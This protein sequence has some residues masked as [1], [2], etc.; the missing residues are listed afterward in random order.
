MKP[1][2][3][4]I[5]NTNTSPFGT[6]YDSF[7]SL[8][9]SIF[10]GGYNDFNRYISKALNLYGFQSHPIYVLIHSIHIDL[11]LYASI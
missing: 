6:G 7:N 1:L 3:L 10:G 9:F 2:Y 4:K 11:K 5:N 8:Y